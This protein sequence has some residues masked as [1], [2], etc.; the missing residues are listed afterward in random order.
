MRSRDGPRIGLE[1]ERDAE[2]Q[3]TGRV[4]GSLCAADSTRGLAHTGHCELPW[5]RLCCCAKV[6]MFPTSEM[7][8]GIQGYIVLRILCSLVPILQFH[9]LL[10]LNRFNYMPDA[11]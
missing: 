8:Q 11:R 7:W 2:N 6:M 4:D 1:H 10:G 5:G 3:R 9:C